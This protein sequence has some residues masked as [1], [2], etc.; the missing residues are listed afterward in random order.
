MFLLFTN[1]TITTTSCLAKSV[2]SLQSCVS[3]IKNKSTPPYLKI[4][5][6]IKC[7]GSRACSIDLSGFSEP[8]VI[9]GAN[10]LSG[11]VR[12][13]NFDYNLISVSKSSQ[14]TIRNLVLKE[15][16]VNKKGPVANDAIANSSCDR[17]GQCVSTLS[18]HQLKKVQLE[19]VILENSRLFGLEIS[20]IGSFL[21]ANSRVIGS[22][23]FG[24]WFGPGIK[25]VDINQNQFRNNG[26]NAMIVSVD[27]RSVPNY[28]RIR[29]NVFE[30]NHWYSVF[31][32]CG[33]DH[34]SACSGGQ[35]LIEKDTHHLIVENNEIKNGYMDARE[36][37]V[38]AIELA[39]LGPDR[40]SDVIIRRNIAK[41]NSGLGIS[42]NGGGGAGVSLFQNE[43][44]S[45]ATAN[46]NQIE[47]LQGP[48]AGNCFA[49]GCIN[50]AT[51]HSWGLGCDQQQCVWFVA[52]KILPGCQVSIFTPDWSPP[53]MLAHIENPVCRDDG[54][55][56]EIPDWIR[57]SYKAINFNI[58]N[59][60]GTWSAPKYLQIRQ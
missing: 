55:N 36:G 15:Y 31:Y 4:S 41:N 1:A 42:D 59:N 57:K 51:I 28:S 53:G 45:N 32:V 38:A 7:T 26:S 19:K 3:Q 5:G 21:M 46:G 16:G 8:I 24:V 10:S 49:P 12:Y 39:P 11:L 27:S 44:Y 37:F 6:M 52:T 18:M 40:I 17:V 43:F 13:D 2:S 47:L 35:F 23:S 14:V 34:K 50:E 58:E 29:N 22:F 9:E 20:E 60:D 30:H 33:A 48:K 54:V 25:Y 56:F